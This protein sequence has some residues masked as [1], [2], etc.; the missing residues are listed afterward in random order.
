MSILYT[1]FIFKTQLSQHL[2]EAVREGKE[3]FYV[4]LLVLLAVFVHHVTS[5]VLTSQTS[6]VGQGFQPTLTS[7]LQELASPNKMFDSNDLYLPNM[8]CKMCAFLPKKT[9]KKQT[10]IDISGRSRYKW[11]SDICI[12]SSST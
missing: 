10:T 11:I 3:S 9:T 5:F 7:P 1:G 8:Y 6:P 2:E 4:L 12:Y